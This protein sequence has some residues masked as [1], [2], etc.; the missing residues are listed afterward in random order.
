M[1]GKHRDMIRRGLGGLAATAAIALL[2]WVIG[3]PSA[4]NG[5]GIAAA[6]PAVPAAARDVPTQDLF[7]QLRG[8][9][10]APKADQSSEALVVRIPRDDLLVILEGN[11]IPTAA[12]VEHTFYFYRCPCG[13]ML[14]HGSF[15]LREYE[16]N[17]VMDA[18]RKNLEMKIVGTSPFL[19]QEDPR[20]VLL[21]FQGEGTA[22]ELAATLNSAFRWIGEARN[23]PNPMR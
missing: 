2:I 6:P 1:T 20:L 8:A 11:E 5:G 14:T 7:E 10:D 15:L 22:E 23:Q 19:L 21:R 18:L 13:T 12:G 9:F 17:D 16:V 4:G 3:S